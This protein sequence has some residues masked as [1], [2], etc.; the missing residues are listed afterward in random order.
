MDFFVAGVN[1]TLEVYAP[2]PP[3]NDATVTIY[4]GSGGAVVSA[5][6]VTEDTVS[7]TLA[8]GAA[9]GDTAVT[10][11]ALTNIVAGRKYRL[12]TSTSEASETVR[13]KRVPGTGTQLLLQSKLSEEH[14]YGAT[15]KGLRMAYAL[16]GATFAEPGRDYVAVFTWNSGAVVQRPI[17][18]AFAMSQHSLVSDVGESDLLERDPAL[19]AKLAKGT[20]LSLAIEAARLNLNDIISAKWP[21]WTLRGTTSQYREAHIWRSLYELSAQFGQQFAEERAYLLDRFKAPLALVEVSTNVDT[22]EDNAIASHEGGTRSR[23]LARG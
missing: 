8:N 6:A 21:A 5:A 11:A 10:V 18:V 13:V 23:R 4:D 7:T 3:D 22:N 1:Q 20:S 17:S 16:S 19:L 9:R 14:P 2:L 15:F 12:G